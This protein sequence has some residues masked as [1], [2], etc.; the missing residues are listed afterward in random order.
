MKVLWITN[1]PFPEVFDEL[2]QKAPVTVGWVHASAM[3]LINQNPE[4]NLGV[5]S[6]YSGKDLRQIKTNNIT[7]FLIP[8]E[9]REI[10]RNGKNDSFWNQIKTQFN[11]DVVHIH[12]TEYPHSFNYVRACGSDKVVVSIQGLVS[13]YERYYLGNIEK[14][15]LV[16]STTLRD[17]VKLD[18][19]FTQKR[20]MQERGKYERLLIRKVNHIIG[21]T[22]WD[23][24]HVWSINPNATYHFCNETLRPAFYKNQ[25]SI[26]NCEKYSIFISQ[27]QYPIK[28]FHQL[29]K[30]LPI[31]LEHYPETKA[32]IAGH[33]YFT[34]RGIRLQG[35]GK[36][37][38]SLIKKNNLADHIFFIGLLNEEEMCQRFIDSHVF[39]CPSAI[40]NSP[41]SVGEAQ[42]LGVPCIASYVGGTMDMISHDETGLLYRF[43]EEELLASQICRLFSNNNLA[44]KIS[45]NS[46]IT[47][48]ER[49][50]K[51]QNATTLLQIYS[52]VSLSNEG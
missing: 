50:N 29:V 10:D 6:F 5:A 21:R 13:I 27:A 14:S 1:S 28:G 43:E 49:H 34:N 44:K 24:N 39:V 33:N 40:E 41:N 45:E 22:S 23:K 38:N 48:S 20:Y 2:K 12:G 18:T 25:W 26:E 52:R 9:L 16:K 15:D 30:A 51:I 47:A 17:L 35:F 7:H 4:L 46:R 11:P 37:V 31:I 32:Y 3:E 42:L 19:I 36:Y 8:Q